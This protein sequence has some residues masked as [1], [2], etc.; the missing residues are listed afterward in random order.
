[1]RTVASMFPYVSSL[2]FVLYTVLPLPGKS[3]TYLPHEGVL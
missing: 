2:L 1:M 3:Y